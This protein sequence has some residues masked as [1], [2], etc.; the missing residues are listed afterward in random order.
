MSPT[1]EHLHVQVMEIMVLRSVR[2]AV[3]VRVL[4]YVRL[5]LEGTTIPVSTYVTVCNSF[6]SACETHRTTLF[7]N[8]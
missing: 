8:A 6:I 2:T 7:V 3:S 1:L 5:L 4:L